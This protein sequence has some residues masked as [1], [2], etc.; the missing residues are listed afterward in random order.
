V[1]LTIAAV[2]LWWELPPAL[3]SSGRQG[4]SL[5]SPRSPLGARLPPLSAQGSAGRRLPG[6]S[7]MG[8]LL[9]AAIGWGL[10]IETTKSCVLV[11]FMLES[12]SIRIYDRFNAEE[13]R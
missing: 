6:R 13:R 1:R 11:S 4:C 8:I 10:E 2:S 3:P 5:F 9:Q 7:A 12:S